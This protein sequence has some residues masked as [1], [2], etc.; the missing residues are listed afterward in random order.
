[1][2]KY[3]EVEARIKKKFSTGMSP[4]DVIALRRQDKRQQ[5]EILD[6]HAAQ[7][8]A[9]T[10]GGLKLRPP[11]D[12]NINTIIEGGHKARVKAEDQAA[13]AGDEDG[14]AIVSKT[15]TMDKR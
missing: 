4:E 5:R 8:Q 11:V 2:G 9:I 6:L 12:E 14:G 10:F 3:E 7:S 1:M 13:H 15:S